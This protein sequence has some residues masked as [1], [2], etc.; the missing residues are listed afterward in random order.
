MVNVYRFAAVRPAPGEAQSIAAVP[1]DVVTAD[2]ARAI[3]A[4][5]PDSFL[6]VSRSDAELPEVPP[7]DDRVY[8]RARDNFHAFLASGR[9]KKDDLP[10]MYVYRIR[11]DND[12]FLGL[13]CCLDTEDYRTNRIRRHELT[14]YDKEED[15]T[16]HIDAVQAHDGPV[17]LLY[18]D[19]GTL[20]SFIESL[21][22]YRKNPDA[23][24]HT[25]Q[26]G[27]HQIFA[28][29]DP[30]GTRYDRTPV[31]GRGQP[32]YRRRPPPRQ[33]RGQPRRPAACRGPAGRWRDRPVHG[34]DSLPMTG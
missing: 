25:P 15:R 14:R 17:V 34:R 12:T 24:V 27:I 5:N 20:F 19:P 1:Y 13:F 10:A 28:V 2:E 22:A 30:G 4:E 3:I 18:Q 33:G 9:L 8:E 32:L 21:I 26:G 31:S 11:Q 16:R 29:T 6:T 23:E 7:Y